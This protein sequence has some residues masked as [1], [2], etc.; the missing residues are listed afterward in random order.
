MIGL[1]LHAFCPFDYCVSQTVNFSLNN[2]DVQCAHN[3]SGLLCG[4]CKEGYSLVSGTSQCKQCTN[5]RLALPVPFA[6]MHG[7]SFGQ[8]APC[9][10]TDCSNRNTQWPDILCQHCWSQS[11][12]LL[13]KY[14]WNLPM[15]YH[16]ASIAWLNLDFGIEACFYDGMDA[17][18]QQKMAAVC[19]P[20]IPLAVGRAN[21]SHQ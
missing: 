3:R 16:A 12:Y 4:A 19:F 6:V 8:L 11:N 13:T 10:Q 1:I 5:S 20:S 15:L 17:C 21:D 9:L 7:S 14:Q 2:T 18:L